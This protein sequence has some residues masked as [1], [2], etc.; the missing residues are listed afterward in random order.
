MSLP[1]LRARQLIASVMRFSLSWRNTLRK[2]RVIAIISLVVIGIGYPFSAPTFIAFLIRISESL[3]L[4]RFPPL[5]V[6]IFLTIVAVAPI[7]LLIRWLMPYAMGIKGAIPSAEDR[8][9]SQI[10]DLDSARANLLRATKYLDDMKKE[11]LSNYQK[12][13]ELSAIVKKLESVS[14]ES[15]EELRAKLDA[16]EIATKWRYLNKLVIG[17]LLGVLSS[18]MASMI[19]SVLSGTLLK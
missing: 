9:H 3:G 14:K 6:V 2:K 12:R 19:W 4:T 16:I 5:L 15:A 8:L 11:I 13:E 18:L 1:Q 17:F 7:F 10:T